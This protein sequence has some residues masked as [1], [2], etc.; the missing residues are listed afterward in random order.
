MSLIHFLVPLP[1]FWTFL[2]AYFKA[3]FKNNGDEA[4]PYFR[5]F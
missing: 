3:K 1:R 2:I 5:V 4:S